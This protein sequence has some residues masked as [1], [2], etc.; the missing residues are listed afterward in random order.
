MK[1]TDIIDKFFFKCG[2]SVKRLRNIND[3]DLYRNIYGEKA[4]VQRA[5]YNIGAGIFNHPAWTN[6]D[7]YSKHYKQ[8]FVHL[9]IDLENFDS[10]PI[11]DETAY[12]VYSSH[13]VE[14]ISMKASEKMFEE[15]YRIL[16]PGGF[17]RVTTPDATFF[18]DSLIENDKSI[19]RYLFI[20]QQ[21]VDEHSIKEL[22]V[23]Y[24][25]TQVS[26]NEV[27]M[28]R[29][30]DDGRAKGKMNDVLDFFI[31]FCDIEKQRV[32]PGWHMNW[33]SIEKMKRILKKVGFGNVYESSYGKSKCPVLKNTTYFDSTHPHISLYVEAIKE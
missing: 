26:S 7:H 30:I 6:I 29:I 15:T 25:A 9:D 27:M 2:L 21:Y 23:N 32:N 13:T 14:H 17:F 5:F 4:V 33:W 10:F 16:K 22:L 20:N 12:V 31:Y 8:N 11:N 3:I 19:W 1:H 18:W 24:F 28:K